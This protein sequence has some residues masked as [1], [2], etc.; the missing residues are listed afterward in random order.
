[1]I[2][3]LKNIRNG[4]VAETGNQN[5]FIGEPVDPID[6]LYVMINTIPT[7][8]V[9][10]VEESQLIEIRVVGTRDDDYNDVAQLQKIIQSNLIN[11]F[12]EYGLYNIEIFNTSI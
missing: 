1:M 9:G 6:S 10:I 5:V 4:I 8:R 12:Q 11:N 7:S 2:D 3:I